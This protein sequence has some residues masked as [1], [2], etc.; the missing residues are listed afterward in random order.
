MK[1]ALETRRLELGWQSVVPSPRGIGNGGEDSTPYLESGKVG[2][3][4]HH[5]EYFYNDN[6]ESEETVQEPKD[7]QL[8]G[9]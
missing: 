7:E 5:G 2:T 8:R 3:I 9:Q 1:Y 6:N 4:T